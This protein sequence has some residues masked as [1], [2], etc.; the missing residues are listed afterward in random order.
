M[1]EVLEQ[2]ESIA[3]LEKIKVVPQKA[4]AKILEEGGTRFVLRQY[5]IEE[6]DGGYNIVN[7]SYALNIDKDLTVFYSVYLTS[8]KTDDIVCLCTSQSNVYNTLFDN[9]LSLEEDLWKYC[10]VE[11]CDISYPTD[12]YKSLMFEIDDDSYVFLLDMLYS[13]SMFAALLE[14]Y[15][16]YVNINKAIPKS[17]WTSFLN[18]L[19]KL[20]SLWYNTRK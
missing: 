4:Y 9:I 13:N 5:K 10:L 19:T 2:E 12:K 18:N 8:D 17:I 3:F 15:A 14:E 20:S 7:I 16:D 11:D 6:L 1:Q